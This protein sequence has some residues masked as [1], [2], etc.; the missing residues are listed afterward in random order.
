MAEEALEKLAG[1]VPEI[2]YDLIARLIPGSFALVAIGSHFREKLA[3][4][5]HL[6]E[7]LLTLLALAATYAL[8]FLL[9]IAAGIV[10]N[11]I[12]NPLIRKSLSRFRNAE[13][14]KLDDVEPW[15]TVREM[16]NQS[17]AAVI[18]KMLAEESFLRNASVLYLIFWLVRFDPVSS[19]PA[20]T[21]LLILIAF[22][23]VQ[24]YWGHLV[25]S[26]SQKLLRPRS[27][28]P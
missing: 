27:I 9:D 18:G 5:A 15:D 16:A 24:Y 4:L 6:N 11:Q 12:A 19:M 20:C 10:L 25:R 17:A 8:G 7:A 2:Y 23:A 21:N 13:S 28:H 1:L 22:L 26:K 14:R 3:P